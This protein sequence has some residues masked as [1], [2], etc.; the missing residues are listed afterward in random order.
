MRE[1]LLA[2]ESVSYV[3]KKFLS[4]EGL[5]DRLLAQVVSGGVLE[6]LDDWAPK[7]RKYLPEQVR[8]AYETMLQKEMGTASNRKRYATLIAHLHRLGIDADGKAR[9]A[10]LAD[11]WR[12][13]YP[14]RRSMLEELEK[15]GY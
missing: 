15:A 13:K 6:E 14:R 2:Q 4:S 7:L 8:Q 1:A 10:A 9:A 11:H 3:R 5:Y 12:Q